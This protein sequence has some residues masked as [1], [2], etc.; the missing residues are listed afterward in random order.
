M[1]VRERAATNPQHAH[2]AV[3]PHMTS[4]QSSLFA[5]ALSWGTA[6]GHG[7]VG[8]QS[9]DVGTIFCKSFEIVGNGLAVEKLG[10]TLVRVL[11]GLAAVSPVAMG[12]ASA[13]SDRVRRLFDPILL[14]GL[15]IDPRPQVS[16][17]VVG[18]LAPAR[19]C[20]PRLRDRSQY[21]SLR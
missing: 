9:P 17:R 5:T 2:E 13:R 3:I 18:R 4:E 11:V 19:R 10:A 14:L 20:R 6:G 12:I 21:Y 7:A 8:P 15:T 1:T 16:D